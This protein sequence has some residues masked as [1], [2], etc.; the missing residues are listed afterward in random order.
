MKYINNEIN[1]WMKN[2]KEFYGETNYMNDC[3][4]INYDDF[5]NN[6]EYRQ[7]I[8]NSINGDYNE[9]Q[10]N[11]IPINGY[12]STFD[13]NTFDGKAQEMKVN[14]R[15]KNILNT[16]YH[17]IYIK[18]LLYNKDA[19]NLYLKYFNIDNQKKEFINSLSD[20]KLNN[21]ILSNNLLNSYEKGVY[22]RLIYLI[23][24]QNNKNF[25]DIYNEN[26]DK[27]EWESYQLY[28]MNKNYDTV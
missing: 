5:F 21:N 25:S 27:E 11:K 2:T 15:Y 20:I 3:I 8:C 28:K 4:K 6:I 16:E 22:G 13:I 7:K 9:Y 1:I 26:N 19:L 14:E 18:I 23:L 24:K 10:L 12:Y 17:D